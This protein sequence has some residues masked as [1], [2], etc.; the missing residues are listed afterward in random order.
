[1]SDR[2]A[3]QAVQELALTQDGVVSRA[4]ARALGVDRWAVA[5]Q[6]EA[7][8]WRAHGVS[9]IAVHCLDLGF[10]A[11]CRVAVWE[12]GEYAA[13]D[14]SSSLTFAGLK[15]FNDGIHVLKPWPLH[16]KGWNGA[17][18]HSSRLWNPDDFEV[19][20][21]LTKT[22]NAVA[23]IRAAMWARTPRAGATIMPMS[24]AQ[25]LAGA[26]PVLLEARRL[27]RHK[28]RPLILQ[29]A[30][31]IADGARAL[32][33]L[34]FGGFCRQRGL[35][36]PSRQVLRQGENGRWYL[37]VYW[38]EYS[39]VVEVE[40]I[41]HDAPESIVDDSFRQ[42]ALTLGHDAVLRVPVLGLRTIPDAFMEQVE[43]GLAARGWR[44]EPH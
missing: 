8:H 26:Q 39:F 3:R 16:G 19:V 42:N 10:R 35:P 34:D 37:D 1:M 4:Q 30:L 24:V 40:G 11:S 18:I 43:A 15:G 36:K 41:H 27:N 12:A 25:R 23:T 5:H 9:S 33:E 38:D 44:R 21:G 2:A 13:L 6:C 29:I 22:R 20:E 17:K 14:G 7:G 32:G 28:R 31:D